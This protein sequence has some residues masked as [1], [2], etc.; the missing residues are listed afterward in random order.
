[1][2]ESKQKEWVNIG[3][4]HLSPGVARISSIVMSKAQGIEQPM[5]K[6]KQSTSTHTLLLSFIRFLCLGHGRY[7]IS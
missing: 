2:T 4:N 5:E 7:K 1:M 3:L 6:K